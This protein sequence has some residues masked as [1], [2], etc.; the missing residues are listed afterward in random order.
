LFFN[1]AV[2][3]C[4]RGCAS[5][6]WQHF[7][8]TDSTSSAG[9]KRWTAALRCSKGV[10]ER[11]VKYTVASKAPELEKEQA[12]RQGQQRL[13]LQRKQEAKR[14]IAM[15]ST[16]ERTK[17]TR[18]FLEDDEEEDAEEYSDVVC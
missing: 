2:S 14:R 3:G 10:K 17:L 6:V 8:Q 1:D 12:E 11:K 7:F 18:N 16:F 5:A 9:H 4:W 13:K 15:R